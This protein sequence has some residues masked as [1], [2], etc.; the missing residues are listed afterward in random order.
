MYLFTDTKGN[1]VEM[2]YCRNGDGALEVREKLQKKLKKTIIAWCCMGG[3]NP[4]SDIG[5][6][7]FK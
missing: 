6:I 2:R 4:A 3:N 7:V 5:P 1:M